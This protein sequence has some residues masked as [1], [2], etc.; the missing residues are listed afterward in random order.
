FNHDCDMM[1]GWS[2]GPLILREGGASYLVAVNSTEVNAIT[3][4]S[5]RPYNGRMNPNTAVRLDGRFL[6]TV[7]NLLRAGAPG[8]VKCLV[9][10]MDETPALPC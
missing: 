1:P 8:T 9:V 6:A 3:H 2:G 4:I 7:E 10:S 5:G